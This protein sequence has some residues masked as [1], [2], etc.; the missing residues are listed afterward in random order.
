MP[1]QSALNKLV[2][3]YQLV[4]RRFNEQRKLHNDT[5]F[6]HFTTSFRFFPLLRMITV[7]PWQV[8]R[9]YQQ[10]KIHDYDD[11]LDKYQQLVT[12]MKHSTIK[13]GV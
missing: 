1:D 2:T 11:I 5:V 8:D 6:Q 3:S 12:Q 13:G 9:V 4:P 7:K 10:L